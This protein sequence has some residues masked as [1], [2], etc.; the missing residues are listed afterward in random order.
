[1]S[2]SSDFLYFVR[3]FTFLRRAVDLWWLATHKS[4]RN[5]QG[6]QAVDGRRTRPWRV[7]AGSHGLGV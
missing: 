3:W 4:L 1:M 6:S 7:Y 2:I 5:I